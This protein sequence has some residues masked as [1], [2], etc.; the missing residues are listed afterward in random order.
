MRKIT[1][2]FVVG[3]FEHNNTKKLISFEFVRSGEILGDIFVP[4]DSFDEAFGYVKTNIDNQETIN[5]IYERFP[6]EAQALEDKIL[7]EHFLNVNTASAEELEALVGVSA[8]RAQAIIDGRP[9]SS[10]K[11]LAQISGISLSMIEGWDISV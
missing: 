6:N 1:E 2:K 9:W 5:E 7:T 11:D 8:T 10:I 3:I 4:F